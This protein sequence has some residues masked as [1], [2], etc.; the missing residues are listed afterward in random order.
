MAKGRLT[1]VPP[2]VFDELNNI[3]MED[4]LPKQSK[5]FKKMVEYSQIGWEARKIKQF[6]MGGK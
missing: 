2:S 5:A 1:Y 3:R 6:L 4:R